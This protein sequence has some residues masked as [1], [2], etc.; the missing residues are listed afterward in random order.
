[1]LR[2]VSIRALLVGY[3]LGD[4]FKILWIYI[5][6]GTGN[7]VGWRQGRLETRW[8]ESRRVGNGQRAL[9]QTALMMVGVSEIG[10]SRLTL[11]ELSPDSPLSVTTTRP[12]ETRSGTH[13][14]GR[15]RRPPRQSDGRLGEHFHFHT[16]RLKGFSSTETPHF[17]LPWNLPDRGQ[18]LP[19]RETMLWS[20]SFP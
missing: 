9:A 20:G 3:N 11:D 18:L 17:D 14:D 1:M 5:S 4:V 19:K 7:L 2:Q 8:A 13:H 16:T 6:V 12:R 15:H 10:G